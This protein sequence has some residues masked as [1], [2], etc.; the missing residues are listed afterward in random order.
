MYCTI[1]GVQYR[2]QYNDSTLIW[3][4]KTLSGEWLY[5][6][7]LQSKNDIYSQVKLENIYINYKREKKLTRILED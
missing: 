4:Y 3:F 1:D 5:V 7:V 2:R 6:N